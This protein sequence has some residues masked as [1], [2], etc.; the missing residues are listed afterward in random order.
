M[1]ENNET[2][3]DMAEV[4]RAYRSGGEE[5][6]QRKYLELLG[7]PPEKIEKALEINRSIRRPANQ[8][9]E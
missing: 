8:N 1:S 7:I 4:A 3:I 5:A 2:K 6:G 9:E